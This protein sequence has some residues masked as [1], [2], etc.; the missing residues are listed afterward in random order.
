MTDE[1]IRAKIRPLIEKPKVADEDL[2]GAMSVAISTEAEQSNKFNLKGNSAK[3][4]A[5]EGAALGNG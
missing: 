1:I 2:I 4:F 5:V 3:V